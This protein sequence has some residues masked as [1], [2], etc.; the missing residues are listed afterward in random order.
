MQIKDIMT[1]S[2]ITISPTATAQEAARQMELYDIGFLP[3]VKD[4]VPAGVVTDRDL[5]IRV[6]GAGL[7]P[8]SVTTADV[9]TTGPGMRGFVDLTDLPGVIMLPEETDVQEAVNFMEEKQIRR[10]TVHDRDYRIVGVVSLADLPRET[11]PAT[12]E[13]K[14]A[15]N[16]S[17]SM[18]CNG[19]HGAA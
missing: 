16:R 13:F 1:R 19:P 18:T 2:T 14:R 7:D 3:V 4:D 17:N 12:Q 6:V 9:M 8:S 10:V 15:C 5:A 11:E